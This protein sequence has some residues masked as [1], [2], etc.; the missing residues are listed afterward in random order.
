MKCRICQ[1][2]IVL[3]PSAQERAKKYGGKP[4]DYTRLFTTHSHC[5][6]KERDGK[7]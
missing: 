3:T 7:K 1:Q 6:L 2:E 5:F 4:S